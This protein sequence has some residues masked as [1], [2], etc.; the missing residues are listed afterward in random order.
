MD[1]NNSAKRMDNAGHADCHTFHSMYMISRADV[2]AFE[3][4]VHMQLGQCGNAED[5]D[6][7]CA[8][9]WQAAVSQSE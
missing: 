1:G 6:G 5:H 3:D 9:T 2:D 8:D 7:G 4:N